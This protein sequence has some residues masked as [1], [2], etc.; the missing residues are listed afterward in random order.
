MKKLAL[1]VALM[2]AV[3]I[4]S[5]SVDTALPAA[6]LEKKWGPTCK[7]NNLNCRTVLAF[8]RCKAHDNWT[9]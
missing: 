3:L 6:S 1:I 4:G 7:K 2:V 5:V 9:A 8:L